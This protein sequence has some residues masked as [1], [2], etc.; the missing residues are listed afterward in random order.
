MGK[1]QEPLNQ[2]HKP[3][4]T[5][6]I[7]ANHKYWLIAGLTSNS[8]TDYSYYKG[9]IFSVDHVGKSSL[10]VSESFE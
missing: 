1:K 2:E 10:L 9:K 7:I 5:H 4:V 3:S 8:N 6:M